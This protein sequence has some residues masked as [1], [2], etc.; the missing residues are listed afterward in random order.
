[1]YCR[2]LTLTNFRNYVHLDLQLSP[3][4]SVFWGDNGQGKSN[5]IEALYLLATTRS[6]RTA[7]ER[8][9]VNWHVPIDPVFARVGA[10]VDRHPAAQRLE[11]ILAEAPPAGGTAGGSAGMERPPGVAGQPP[12]ASVRR[13][14]RVNG[15]H[16]QPLELIGHLNVVL[17]SPEDVELIAGPAAGR[18]RYLDITLCQVDHF[19]LR[20]AKRFERVL[21][22]RNAL[23][24]EARE[25]PVRPDQF[26]YWDTQLVELGTAMVVA[27]LRALHRMN[28]LMAT[29]YPRLANGA[30]DLTV[31]YRSSVPLD[32]EVVALLREETG[33]LAA[34]APAGA[35]ARLREGFTAQLAAVRGRERQQAVTLVGPHRDDAG[36]HA[37]EVDLR[38]YGSRGQQR[39]AALS[40]KL[41]EVELMQQYTSERPVLLLDD[42]MSELDP[43]RRR[44]LQ[45]VL[46][47]QE[48]QQVLLTATELAFFDEDFLRHTD[49]YQVEA[50]TIRCTQR[51]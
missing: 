6:Y 5:L 30:G 21:Q 15:Q 35:V 36:F 46:Q 47:E 14:V 2:H 9:M 3:H 24:R 25:R 44:F 50:G 17:F 40:L 20:T 16:R 37:G 22:Q 27:R 32:D 23:L 13:R 8:E 26:D 48:Q 33:D 34:A 12:A 31:E 29:I 41:A 19:Y 10:E 18:R 4:L 49:V 51:A 11:V 38:V 45:R 28:Q 43:H 7:A 39:A 42:V 1:M